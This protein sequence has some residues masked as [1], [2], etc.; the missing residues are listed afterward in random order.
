M[1]FHF[2]LFTFHILYNELIL[3]IKK[4]QGKQFLYSSVFAI[5][6]KAL[7]ASKTAISFFVFKQGTILA[8]PGSS[9]IR[10]LNTFMDR[11]S[12]KHGIVDL[13]GIEPL[14]ESSS[15]RISPITVS[16]FLF[17]HQGTERQ[18]PKCGSF[19][20]FL[21]PQ[22]FGGRVFRFHEAGHPRLGNP[23]ADCRP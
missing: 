18:V 17:P 8:A 7:K 6:P 19:I 20:Y 11:C 15:R 1:F 3:Q 13:R 22:S 14:S 9:L 2:L 5:N 23:R 12:P 4:E 16:L 21:P 10:V